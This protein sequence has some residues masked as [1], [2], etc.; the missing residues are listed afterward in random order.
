MSSDAAILG[1]QIVHDPFSSN[2]DGI[3]NED[4]NVNDKRMALP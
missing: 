4:V 3:D 1:D 2:L